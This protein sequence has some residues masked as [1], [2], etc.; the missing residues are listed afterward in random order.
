MVLYRLLQGMF[1]A[2]LVPLSQ[3]I[4]LDIYPI[5][6]RGS[7]MAIWGVGVMVGPI[8]GPTL[9][10][11]LT[12]AYNW[13]WVFYVN[14][15][16]GLLAFLGLSAFLPETL[17]NGKLRFDWIGFGVLSLGI[18]A[19]QLMLDRGQQ[20][21]WFGSDEII[22]EAVLACVGFYLFTV[23]MLTAEKPFIAPS[24]FAD[25]NFLSGFLFMFVIG[26]VLLA[27][28]ALL[29][30]YLENLA[31]YPVLT[32]GLLMAPRGAGTM[33]AMMVA[34]RLSNRVDPR[35]VML[36]GIGLIA[37]SLW[38]MT[39]WTPDID[40]WTLT[41][42]SVIQGMGLGFV[43]IPLQVVAFGTLPAALRTD[44]TALISL[45]RNVGSAVGISVVSFLLTQNTQVMHAE[46]SEHVTAFNRLFELPAIHQMWNLATVTGRA[47]LDSEVT[48][49]ASIIAYVDDF[50]FMLLVT[51]ASAPLLLMMRTA[52]RTPAADAGHAAVLD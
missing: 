40:A 30:P 34:G 28:S 20:K 2:A 48:R 26:M 16:F 18:A 19:L 17:K 39:G 10:G 43:F 31:G 52:R 23:H 41:R 44:G 3:A 24:I 14:L 7:A 46:L 15:P 47:A 42:N 4:L 8:L 37:L 35:L 51:L 38:E 49:Q 21:D 13:R 36:G 12:D 32:A 50:K 33:V 11:Y 1:G 5:E 27:S 22:I 45:V 9:G 6:Q 25:R 29:A